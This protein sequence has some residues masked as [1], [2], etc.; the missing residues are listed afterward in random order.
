MTGKNSNEDENTYDIRPAEQDVDKPAL[1]F[2]ATQ[3]ELRALVKE[4]FSEG[5]IMDW[6]FFLYGW[7]KRTDTSTDMRINRL[8]AYLGEETFCAITRKTFGDIEMQINDPDL[9]NLYIWRDK[10]IWFAV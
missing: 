7:C 6:A 5:L 2:V 10:D 3:D 4:A 9:W 8:R 1:G